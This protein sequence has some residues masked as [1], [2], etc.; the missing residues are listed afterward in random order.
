MWVQ[1]LEFSMYAMHR[2]GVL[3]VQYIV[4]YLVV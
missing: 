4:L 3:T 2:F 1:V